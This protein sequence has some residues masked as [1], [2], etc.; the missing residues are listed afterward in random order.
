MGKL[1]ARVRAGIQREHE[2]VLVPVR[3]GD[4]E[5]GGNNGEG[6]ATTQRR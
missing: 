2:L 6:G 3:P 4:P 5:N 1:A